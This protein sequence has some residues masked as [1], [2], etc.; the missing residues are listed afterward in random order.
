MMAYKK[1]CPVCQRPTLK[2]SNIQESEA[3]DDKALWYSC[4]CGIMFQQEPPEK[5]LKNSQWAM[6][7]FDIKE[8]AEVGT[9]AARVYAPIIEELTYGRKFFEVGFGSG[10]V[11]DHMRSRGWVSFGMDSNKDIQET[12]RL[13]RDDFETTDRLYT[14]QYDL[15]WM[16]HVLE[17]LHDPIG[18]LKKAYETLQ[19]DGVLYIATPDLGFLY[20][21]PHA[22]PHWSRKENYIIWTEAAL[23]RELEAIGFEI[24]L[25]RRN[26]HKRFGYYHDLHIIA[27]KRFY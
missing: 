17:K 18:A 14:K 27:Q 6:A 12:D 7:H 15:V 22:W 9:H 23:V 20:N 11:I 5:V 13:M 4:L 8:Y 2:A 16:S 3:P 21:E 24:I 10:I 25:K 19:E 26:F 1:K